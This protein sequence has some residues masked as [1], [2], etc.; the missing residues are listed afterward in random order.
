MKFRLKHHFEPGGQPFL[1]PSCY[2]DSSLPCLSPQVE[3]QVVHALPQ[4]VLCYMYI[5]V[6][7]ETN[8]PSFSHPIVTKETWNDVGSVST[9]SLLPTASDFNTEE[10]CEEII[11]FS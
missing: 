6:K 3:M 10:Y 8:T 9:I 7:C 2:T 4:L 11:I 1:F 5:F